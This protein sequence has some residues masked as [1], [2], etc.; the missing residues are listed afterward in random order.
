[1]SDTIVDVPGVG[2]VSFPAGMSDADIEDAIKTK[3]LPQAKGAA[4]GKALGEG[5]ESADWLHTGAQALS[6][7]LAPTSLG[8]LNDKTG[9]LVDNTVRQLAGGAS[10]GYADEASAFMNSL[11]NTVGLG[12]KSYTE[13]LA[14]ERAQDKA[15]REAHPYIAG[16][17]NIAGNL[18]SAIA[19]APTIG[20]GASFPATVMRFA[21]LGGG[22]GAIQGFGEGEGGFQNRLKQAGS[23]G[24]MGAIG[25][26]AVP[27]AGALGSKVVEKV[28][29][30][31]LR[32]LGEALGGESGEGVAKSLS[33]AAPDGGEAP[34]LV[35]RLGNAMVS[36]ANKLDTSE[37]ARN[38]AAR[39]LQQK[40]TP[41]ELAARA[42][43]LGPWAMGADLGPSLLSEANAARL[44]SGEINSE[45][46][47]VLAERA[48][49]YTPMLTDAFTGG[50]DLPQLHTAG[51]YFAANE[52][53]VGADMYGAMRDAGL[54]TSG[55]MREMQQVPAVQKAIAS[56]Q[57]DAAEAGARLT[58]IDV[59]H[60]VKQKLGDMA[61]PSGGLPNRDLPDLATDWRQAF[62]SANPTAAAADAAMTEAKSLP[63]FM[64]LGLNF[65]LEGTTPKAVE[66]SAPSVLDRLAN[67]SGHQQGAYTLG[68]QN[69]GR[70]SAQN[71][72]L[73]FASNLTKEKDGVIQKLT[74]A[75]GQQG[76]EKVMNAADA[77][78]TFQQTANK[79]RGGS[80][81][82]PN[83]QDL[84]ELKHLRFSLGKGGLFE[85]LTD[86]GGE[87]L[88][89]L[90]E[91]SERVTDRIGKMLT[92]PD[93]TENLIQAIR[94]VL[95]SKARTGTAKAAAGSAA[96]Q[97]MGRE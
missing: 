81:T 39:V 78:R 27:F 66:A 77:V 41:D 42:E 67:A 5:G 31:L 47:K 2:H 72:P 34:G 92:D 86:T 58:P 76:Q 90:I 25:G 64:D 53:Q 16:A 48:K 51:K 17:A 1:M 74:A 22:L 35:Q 33:A 8:L 68:V 21:G 62:H 28:G 32:R 12:G 80:S 45:V 65:N 40:S 43:Q 97:S 61:F 4:T 73:S 84:A 63:E 9:N 6:T 55:E 29:T 49:Q 79:L 59:M 85:R 91:P 7:L 54:N 82:V 15:F 30:P 24:V 38:I 57:A 26:A 18:G 89:D 96:G 50:A 19:L 87:M 36:G 23:E 94:Y 60:R 71:N 3:I 52:K 37:A 69:A 83:V 70:M 44:S 95:A 11:P 88:R 10:A 93:E 46:D 75:L 56:V 13:N 20:I 14:Q